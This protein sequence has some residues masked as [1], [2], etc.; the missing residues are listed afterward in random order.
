[1]AIH[2]DPRLYSG[3][4]VVFNPNPHVA[5]YANLLARQEARRGA[6]DEYMKNLNKGI[7]SAGL[8]NI[9]RPA[10]DKQLNDFQ[11]F[12]MQ[13]SDEIRKRQNGADIALMNKYQDVMNTVAESKGEEE[14]KKPVIEMM[15]DPNKR[16]RINSDDVLASIHSHDQPLYLQDN[17]GQLARNPNRKSL[18][19]S[20]IDFNPKPFEQDK[21]FKQ[22][23]DVKRSD[24]PPVMTKNMK[25]L[26][27][28]TTTTSVFDKDAKD[29]IATR[30]VSDYMNNPSFKKFVGNLNPKDYN[31]EFEKSFGHP[32]QNEGDLAAAYTLKG[33]Q[34]KTVK[35]E[36]KDDILARERQMAK[37]NHDYRMGEINYRHSLGQT[38]DDTADLW[39]DQHIKDIKDKAIK[40][41][42]K[43]IVNSYN[44]KEIKGVKVPLDPVLSNILGFS[45]KS[46]GELML[47]DDGDFYKLPYQ[48]DNN[49]NPVPDKSGTGFKVDQTGINKISDSD[50]KLGFGKKTAGT[51]HTN[52]EMEAGKPQTQTYNYKW[53]SITQTQLEN[54]AKASGM[55]VDEYKKQ[56]G[57]E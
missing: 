54:A 32:I 28:T 16:D 39:I 36:M 8:R 52:E 53:K 49:Y 29:L 21:Y 17:N 55:S 18:D 19:I 24:L 48:T 25:D 27:Q 45:D 12:A 7:N 10:F 30:A 26:T 51:K 22:F 50:L 57:L 41:G 11:Q 37:L 5:L 34:Q 33:M 9:D 35:S 14:K 1:M 3:G 23:E 42:T 46:K 40:E 44:G 2:N 4:S 56:I 47:G 15:L 6:F 31:D 43:R 13:H 20:S 38:D